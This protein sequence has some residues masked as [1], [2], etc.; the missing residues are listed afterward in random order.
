[1]GAN[2]VEERRNGLT[3]PGKH[4]DRAI[5]RF[6]EISELRSDLSGICSYSV[7]VESRLG[8]GVEQGW[9]ELKRADARYAD[10]RR[11]WELR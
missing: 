7:V 1:L 11:N 2:D 3:W 6:R 8:N 5:H 4:A 10:G 9:N